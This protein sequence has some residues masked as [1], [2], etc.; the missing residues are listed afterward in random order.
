M[1][2]SWFLKE[3]NGTESFP[4]TKSLNPQNNHAFIAL[5]PGVRTFLT[6]Y[7]GE[8]ILEFGGGDIGRI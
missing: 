8:K 6:G 7:D 2:P 3:E 5:D 1:E 4:N